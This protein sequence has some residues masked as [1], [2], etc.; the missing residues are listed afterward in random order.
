MDITEQIQILKRNVIQIRLSMEN[1]K[2]TGIQC[3]LN[4]AIE[5]GSA[6]PFDTNSRACVIGSAARGTPQRR[7]NFAVEDASEDDG[8]AS[9]SAPSSPDSR[10]V[11]WILPG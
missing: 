1:A 8:R 3:D 7:L 10:T 11:C 4:R 2:I 9:C 6:R 5:D